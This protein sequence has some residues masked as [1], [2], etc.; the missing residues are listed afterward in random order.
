MSEKYLCS[1]T[2]TFKT[3]PSHLAIFPGEFDVFQEQ[4]S[5]GIPQRL[6]TLL[7][8]YSSKGAFL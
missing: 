8:S 2:D 6:V 5:G 3:S 1:R 7:K 4:L